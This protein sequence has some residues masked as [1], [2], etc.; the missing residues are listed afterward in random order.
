MYQRIELQRRQRELDALIEKLYEDRVSG[1]LSESRMQKLLQKYEKEN[2]QVLNQLDQL[3]Q[4][5]RGLLNKENPD[6]LRMILREITEP[7]ELTRDVLFRLIEKIEVEQGHFEKIDGAR[8]KIQTIR[9]YYRFS[10]VP[11][12]KTYQM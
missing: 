5:D 7:C 8:R 2:D 6:Q 1:L 12:Q 9:I 11:I 10:G 4:G 3:E